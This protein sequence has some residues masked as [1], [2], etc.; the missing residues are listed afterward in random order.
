MD[1]GAKLLQNNNISDLDELDSLLE[2][3]S[4]VRNLI[5]ISQYSD[6]NAIIKYSIQNEHYEAF[7]WIMEIIQEEF[8]KADCKIDDFE[9]YLGKSIPNYDEFIQNLQIVMNPIDNGIEKILDDNGEAQSFFNILTYKTKYENIY[10]ISS[11]NFD[12]RDNDFVQYKLSF[13]H[14][15]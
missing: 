1:K 9:C 6:L 15:K 12:T 14:K 7:S 2:L 13:M 10:L 4:L 8:L 5:N 3:A 11:E